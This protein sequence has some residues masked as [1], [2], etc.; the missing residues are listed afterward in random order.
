MAP[1]YCFA[2]IGVMK[3]CAEWISWISIVFVQ[4]GLIFCSAGCWVIRET[5]QEAY[6]IELVTLR[7]TTDDAEK[8]DMKDAYNNK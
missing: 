7:D 2:F 5:A 1:I 3:L 6:K 4:L 8:E